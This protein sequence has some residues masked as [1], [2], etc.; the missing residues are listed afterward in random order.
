VSFQGG[1]G[2]I[3]QCK[4]CVGKGKYRTTKPQTNARSEQFEGTKPL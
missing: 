3:R 4:T 1:A 2:R